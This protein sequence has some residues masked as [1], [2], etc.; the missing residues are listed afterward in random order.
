MQIPIT[1]KRLNEWGGARTV[2]DAE[3]MVKAGQVMEAHY[4]DNHVHGAVLWNNRRIDT[5]FKITRSGH[6]DSECPCYANR[7]RGLICA[8]VMALGLVLVKRATDPNREAKYRE[9]LRRASRLESIKEEE[10]LQR[11]PPGTPGAILT[12]I[13]FGLPRDW[14]TA[15]RSGHVTIHCFADLAG[16]RMP[17]E[18]VPA[19][20]KLG[21]GKRDEARLFVMEDIAEGP[22]KGPL[23]VGI[24]DL[25]NLLRISKGCILPVD[26]A[27][28]ITVNDTA[29]STHFRMDLDGETGELLLFAHTEL[30][31]MRPGQFPT[32]VVGGKQGWA[33]GAGH[34]WPMGNVLPEPYHPVYHDPIVVQRHDLLR[35]M[36]QELKVLATFATIESDLSLDLFTVDPA[37]PSFRLDVHGSPASLSATL[38]AV[39]G[40][41]ELVCDRSD[42]REHFAIPDPDDLMR[43]TGRNRPSEHKA[44]AILGSSGFRGEAGDTL[45]SIV[46]ERQ[47]LTFLGNTLPALRRLGWKID[48]VGRVQPYF[49]EMDYVTP[50]IHVEDDDDAPWFDVGFDF[51]DITGASISLSEIQRAINKGESFL[52]RGGK[53]V[54]IDTMAIESMMDIFSDCASS[55][56]DEAGHFRLSNVYAPSIKSS[57]DALDGVD[58]ED[59]P[60]WRQQSNRSNRQMEV[61]K[62]DLAD[63]VNATLRPYQH[64]GVN[65]LRFLETNQFG[66][67]LADEMGLGKTLQT[68]AWLTL[69]RA[70]EK[71]RGKP[72][73]IVCPTSLVQNWAEEAAKFTPHIKVLCISGADRHKLWEQV[74]DHQLIV[75][76]YAL[77]R[78][79]LDQHLQHEYAAVVLDEAQH[80]KN[81]STRNAQAAKQLRAHQRIVLTGTP[82]ENGVSDLWSIMDF[83]MPGYLA[84]HDVFRTNYELPISRGGPDADFAQSKL[85]KKLHPFMLRRLKRDVAKDLPPK[86]ERISTCTLTADQRLV[87]NELLRASQQKIKSMVAEKGFNRCRMEVLTTLLRL[88]QACCHLDLLKLPDLKAK[89]PSGKLDLFFELID[90]ALDG[91]HRILVFSQFVTMLKILRKEFDERKVGYCY[92]DGS[93][94]DRM[95]E[96]HRFNTQRE[97]PIF[98]IS[99]KAGGTGLNLTGADMVIH[100]DP[101]W[102]PAVENQATDRAYR[103]GQ[104]RT[105]YSVKLITADTVEEKVLA[106]Q[107]R[108]KAVIDATVETDQQMVEK[109]SWEDVQSLLDL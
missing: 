52:D 28:A 44:L 78:R 35:F 36:Q 51:E 88:R 38:Y 69:E 1:L 71:A 94:K 79:D 84:G 24:R 87:Y 103:I 96:V 89:K 58:V 15:A 56:S 60:S 64:D 82:V 80:I 10:Y 57:L 101:W 6:I 19:D 21:I 59:T 106:M 91:G 29:V 109:M 98:L 65:W 4:D 25:L 92:L 66:G 108:K 50:V 18:A 90:E 67:I 104:K 2:R 7:E 95:A 55:E 53:R 47:V 17:L 97:I 16:E 31:F 76:S 48:L 14:V 41:I 49:E 72:A 54:L 93:T 75:T 42:A 62:V 105:V 70:D 43:Y 39:Y 23:Q 32:Y 61:E 107:K 83:L 3:G 37:T 99:L 13:G 46:G 68:L 81:R 30:P 73:L 27:A 40:D 12:A 11:V 9:E 20:R 86:I 63:K 102:N 74:P 26:G 85:R 34:L 8:H 33:Y 77:V 5:G 22:V 45:T 100:F